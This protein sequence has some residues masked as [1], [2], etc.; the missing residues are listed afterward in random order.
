MCAVEAPVALIIFNRPE[1]TAR[2]FAEL[3]KA[4]PRKLLVVADGPRGDRSGEAEKCEA[5]RAVVERIDWDCE[6]FRNYSDMNLGCKKRVSSGLDW[7]FGTVDR[8]IV[9]ED[10]VLPHPTFFR[11]CDELLGRYVDDSRVGAI[12]GCNV[13]SMTPRR[14]ESYYFSRHLHVWGWASWSRAWKAYDVD[15]SLWPMVRDNGYLNSLIPNEHSLSYWHSILQEVYDGKID[16]WDYQWTFSC[17][18]HGMMNIIPCVNLISNIGFGEFATHTGAESSVSNMPT[19]AMQFPLT[20]PR[21]M[22]RDEIADADSDVAWGISP[23]NYYDNSL[24]STK[25]L[26]NFVDLV[27]RAARNERLLKEKGL[28]GAFRALLKRIRARL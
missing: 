17:W 4:R 1:T 28:K 22:M 16:T 26:R 7:V 27:R 21:S 12:C 23:I 3:A 13:Q 2:V 15:M 20:H 9:I 5:T 25:L 14:P 6:V 10:D 18:V 11:F 24:L 8:A 19:E